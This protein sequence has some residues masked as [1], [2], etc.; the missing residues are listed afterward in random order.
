MFHTHT[1]PAAPTPPPPSPA[2]YLLHPISSVVYIA[3]VAKSAGN[4]QANRK[5]NEIQPPFTIMYKRYFPCMC[6]LTRH[7]IRIAQ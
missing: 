6:M 1:P 4:A 7:A 5:S 3:I 2:Q